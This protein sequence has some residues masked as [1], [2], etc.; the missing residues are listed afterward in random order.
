[1]AGYV[2]TNKEL[3]EIPVEKQWSTGSAKKAVIIKLIVNG[4]TENPKATVT[5]DGNEET[6]WTY[7]FTNLDK[8]DSQG[9]LITYTV[10][11]TLTGYSTTITGSMAG[12]VITNKELTEVTVI[13]VWSGDPS[14]DGKTQPT[15]I[16]VQLYA[17]G[18]PLG[19]AVE[20][21]GDTWSYTWSNL[22]LRNEDG[23]K[24]L[25]T[26]TEVEEGLI[27]LTETPGY[28]YA[29]LDGYTITNTYIP[30]ER[31]IYVHKIWDDKDNYNNKRPMHIEVILKADGKAIDTVELNDDNKW[32]YTWEK[33]DYYKNGKKI[34]YSI[35][36]KEVPEYETLIDGDMDTVFIITNT[37]SGTGG[38]VPPNPETAD[39]IY[40]YVLMLLVCILGLFK[41]TYL[42]KNN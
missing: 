9:N 31:E 29:T 17:D 8:Y 27:K 1:M 7:I 41:F 18:D 16:L 24:I 11:E 37:Y 19:D 36:E 38:D 23:D 13:K 20:V 4:D 25:Y 2:I 21:T 14:Q 22:D 40:T 28:Y 35:E 39:N 10:D 42:Y 30:L 32:S 3:T 12:Y 6:P 34:V 33:L 5:L 15:S 26:V